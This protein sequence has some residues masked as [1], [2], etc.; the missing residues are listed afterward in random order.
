MKV[1]K[2]CGGAIQYTSVIPVLAHV[3]GAPVRH[4]IKCLVCDAFLNEVDLID[5]IPEDAPDEH[6]EEPYCTPSCKHEEKS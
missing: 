3:D 1:H 5:F 4:H 6:E 2:G